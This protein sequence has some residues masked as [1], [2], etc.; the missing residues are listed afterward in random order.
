M[1]TN[2]H[3]AANDYARSQAQQLCADVP[4][5]GGQ[6]VGHVHYANRAYRRFSIALPSCARDIVLVVP[7]TGFA[8][9]ATAT[10]GPADWR[11]SMGVELFR[12]D[13]RGYTAWLTE[14][15]NGYVLNIQ[16]SMNPSDARVHEASCRTITG[17]PPRGR[18]WT[19]P[20]VKVCSPSLTELD[21]WA[22][23]HAESAIT[24]CAICQPLSQVAAPVPTRRSRS[25][26]TSA[27]SLAS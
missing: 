8:V 10:P 3:A 7:D 1:E 22:L 26:N 20:Y 27:C 2:T 9:P 14:N 21:A 13:D 11:A 19:G 23:S 15:A 12:D 18:T 4:V 5:M 24:R 25:P 6:E 17:T 16:R